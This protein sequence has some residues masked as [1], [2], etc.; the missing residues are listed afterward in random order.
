MSFGSKA[1]RRLAV[2]DV[3]GVILPK[4]RYLLLL[5]TRKLNFPRTLT[6]I[7]LGLL[8]EIGLLSLEKVLRKIYELFEGI[9]KE[10]FCQTLKSI[11]IIPEVPQVFQKLRDNGYQIALISSG[12]PDFLI[13]DLAS[14]LGADYSRGIKLELANNRFTGKISGDVIKTNGKAIVLEQILKKENYSKANCVVVADDRNNLPMSRLCGKTVGYN[15]DPVLAVKCDYAIK[16]SLQDIVPFLETSVKTPRNLYTR[17][18]VFREIIHMGSFLIPL[19]CQFLNI[20]RYVIAVAILVTTVVYAFSELAR[21]TS[22]GLPLFITITN[23]AAT[24]E[25]KWGFAASPIFFAF[26]IALPLVFCPPQIGFAAITVL[27]LGDG[28]A[29]IVGKRLGR[30]VLPYNKT[31]Q[32][33]G[34]LAGILVSATASFLFVTPFR[35]TVASMIS[36]AVESLPLPIDDNI[37]IPLT[38][39]LVLTIIP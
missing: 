2:F 25:E 29:K 7:F 4:R 38:A 5:A 31:K 22:V 35:A 16:G 18:D 23:R 21:K 9:S 12:L 13:E 33:E 8:Y 6:L 27:T 3:E 14:Q 15:P 11:P 30:R 26:G 39:G 36:M 32:L 20:N 19:L 28:T 37:A 34:T 17:S 1:N 24:G 10:E